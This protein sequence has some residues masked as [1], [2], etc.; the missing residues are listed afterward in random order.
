[1]DAQSESLKA[2]I[3]T[4]QQNGEKVV[5]IDKHLGTSGS[6]CIRESSVLHWVLSACANEER[7][8]EEIQGLYEEGTM[9]GDIIEDLLYL[10]SWKLIKRSDDEWNYA[11][12]I[13]DL[14]RRVL[15]GFND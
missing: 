1:M 8:G 12:E 11:P 5:W 3:S 7:Y 15:E 2:V 14:G 9:P 4:V 6:K 10:E 13:T